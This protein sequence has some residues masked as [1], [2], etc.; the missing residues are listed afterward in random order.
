MVPPGRPR[1]GPRLHFQFEDEEQAE[2]VRQAAD[3]DGVDQSDLIRD[4]IDR[5]LVAR[6]R[7]LR[8]RDDQPEVT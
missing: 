5:G 3:E 1:K 2:A 7:R 4:F 6:K 8:R